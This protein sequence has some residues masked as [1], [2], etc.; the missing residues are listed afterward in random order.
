VKAGCPLAKAV[1]A[2]SQV[3]SVVRQSGERRGEC[4]GHN[5]SERRFSIVIAT[6]GQSDS[7]GAF[8]RCEPVS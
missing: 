7:A 6:S 5:T 1:V 3:A 8:C 4:A 2:K